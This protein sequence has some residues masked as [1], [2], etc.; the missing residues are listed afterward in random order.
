MALSKCR[1]SDLGLGHLGTLAGATKLY[2]K[3]STQDIAILIALGT[4]G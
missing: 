4:M 1:L 3:L 2:L